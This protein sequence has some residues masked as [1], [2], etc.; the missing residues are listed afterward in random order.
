MKNDSNR[1]LLSQLCILKSFGIIK[2]ENNNINNNN[3]DNKVIS[4]KTNVNNKKEITKRN[5]KNEIIN[6]DNFS[7]FKDR[8]INNA[9]AQFNKKELIEF[10]NKYNNIKEYI[11][12]E[13]YGSIVSLLLDGEVKVKGKEYIVFVY[14]DNKFADYFNNLYNKV[15][16]LLYSIYNI[17]YKVIAINEN[18]WEII[19]KDFNSSMKMGMNK[20]NLKDDITLNKKENKDSTFEN[21]DID[22]MFKEIVK[23]E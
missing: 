19:K 22:N 3:H 17:N 2:K 13:I 1:L 8:R 16:N 15:E 5:K 14:H 20:Y 6:I 12:D 10:K 21:N 9:L 11:N 18:D 7:D 23:Y 4:N